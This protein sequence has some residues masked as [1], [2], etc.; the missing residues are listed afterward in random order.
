[1]S[2]VQKD[3]SY[4]DLVEACAEPGCPVCRLSL[5][6]VRR[7]VGGILHEYVNDPGVRADF[8][9]ARGY[10]NEHAWLM[11]GGHGLGVAI[12]QRDVIETVLALIET[13]S[14]GYNGRQSPR[15]LLR[16]VRP[17]AECPVCAHR[18][19]ME[20]ITLDTLLQHIGDEEL[21]AALASSA[22]LCLVHFSRAL[23]LVE[24]ADTLKQ[25]VELQRYTLT[26]L[27]DDLAEFI[28][29]NDY[30][31]RDEGFGKEGDSWRRSIGIVSGEYGVR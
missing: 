31:F 6:L 15:E 10:C 14:D 8:R 25:L 19:A 11:S 18:R 23:E 24:D 2:A 22:G 9:Q 26:E 28:R 30:R 16:R 29:K 27:R 1:M 21:A 5:N 20:D 12:L 4:F 17:T 13:L 7:Y 3:M